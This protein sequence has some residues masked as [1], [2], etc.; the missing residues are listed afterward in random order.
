MIY[1][2]LYT[3]LKFIVALL[4]ATL[5][6]GESNSVLILGPRGSGKTS[7][8]ESCLTDIEFGDGDKIKDAVLVRLHGLLET[9]D[10][11]ALKKITQQLKMEGATKDKVVCNIQGVN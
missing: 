4:N 1:L 6:R 10:R 8:L 7:L 9:N 11:L 3:T 5:D 2:I